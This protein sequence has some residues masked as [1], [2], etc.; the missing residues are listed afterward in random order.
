MWLA[1]T[2]LGASGWRNSGSL[3]KLR[4]AVRSQFLMF[5]G[6][7]LTRAEFF[8]SPRNVFGLR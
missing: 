1:V 3:G 4:R 5:A 2:F 8:T 7:M 6:A